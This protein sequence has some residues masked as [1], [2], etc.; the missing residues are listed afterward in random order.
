MSHS[1]FSWDSSLHS[2]TC[3]LFSLWWRGSGLFYHWYTYR[4]RLD[5]KFP[6]KPSLLLWFPL[7]FLI[8]Y[9]PSLFVSSH[10]VLYLLNIFPLILS[11][12]YSS[13]I[14]FNLF[15]SFLL[16]LIFFLF[17]FFV[18]ILP[19]LVSFH[20]IY[21]HL[22][23]SVFLSNIT[24]PPRLV[25][26]P[27]FSHYMYP[28]VHSSLISFCLISSPFFSYCIVSFLLFSSHLFS[29]SL[30]SLYNLIISLCLPLCSSPLN[31]SHLVLSPFLYCLTLHCLLVSSPFSYL[32]FI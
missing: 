24:S 29:S 8:L 21:S 20:F 13:C 4:T 19:P 17:S 23:C 1:I 15:L 25:S 31:L 18:L 3:T 32:F 9:Y 7:L 14:L 30:V 26:S 6:L 12:L 16:C 11:S 28:Y 2:H 10:L 27:L 22:I 5:P